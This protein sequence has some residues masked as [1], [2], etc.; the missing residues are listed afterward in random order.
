M[1]GDFATNVNLFSYGTLQEEPV[2]RTTFGRTLQGQPDA[3]T[4]YVVSR[5]KID[6]PS[7]IAAS[8]ETHRP[9]ARHTGRPNARNRSPVFHF[10]YVGWVGYINPAFPFRP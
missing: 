2:Q 9:I 10:E 5:V 3:L 4:G 6:D 7:V 8:R 1:P